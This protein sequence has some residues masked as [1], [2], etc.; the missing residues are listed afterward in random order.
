MVDIAEAQPPRSP[1]VTVVAWL[2][3]AVYIFKAAVSAAYQKSQEEMKEEMMKL[4]G[5]LDMKGLE[6][7]GSLLG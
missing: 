5:G 6:Q 3:M 7:L 1:F 4:T 2:M